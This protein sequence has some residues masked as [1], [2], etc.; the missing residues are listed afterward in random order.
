MR[1]GIIWLYARTT[2]PGRDFRRRVL[3]RGKPASAIS[4][5]RSRCPNPPSRATSRCWKAP[6]WLNAAS[7][8]NAAPRGSK[9]SRWRRRSTI[10]TRSAAFG[11]VA[12]ASSTRCSM[13]F[14]RKKTRHCHDRSAR[15]HHHPRLRSPPP[16][17][18]AHLDRSPPAGPAPA[19]TPSSTSW[20]CAR[21]A[22]GATRCG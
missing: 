9:R 15:V 6:G 22:N 21:A 11:R 20:T 8:S 5:S 2:K 13:T 12:S 10:S 3:P 4:L 7:T 1:Y 14:K 18:L 17:G 16:A 19:L